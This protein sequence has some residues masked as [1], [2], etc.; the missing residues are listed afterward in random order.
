M[1][2]IRV[3]TMDSPLRTVRTRDSAMRDALLTCPTEAELQASAASN[4]RVDLGMVWDGMQR[5]IEALL[6]EDQERIIDRFGAYRELR[7]GQKSKDKPSGTT[8]GASL[9]DF[10]RKLSAQGAERTTAINQANQS[11]WD[12]RLGR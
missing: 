11:Y 4:G 10:N 3:S 7:A 9:A 1:K 5:A 6:P 12:R 8:D 2:T